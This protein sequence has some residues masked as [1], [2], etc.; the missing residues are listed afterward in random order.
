MGDSSA[1][2]LMELTRNMAIEKAK[3]IDPVASKI[4][5]KDAFDDSNL[6]ANLERLMGRHWRNLG[7]LRLGLAGTLQRIYWKSGSGSILVTIG[8]GQA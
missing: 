1:A 2:C 6:L 8:G 4:L 5:K 3:H 7:E